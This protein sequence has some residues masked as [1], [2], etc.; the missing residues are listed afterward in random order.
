MSSPANPALLF[1]KLNKFQQVQI[2]QAHS[3]SVS[4]QPSQHSFDN[5]M[6]P[7]PIVQQQLAPP[8]PSHPASLQHGHSLSLAAV[9][10]VPLHSFMAFNAWD[11]FHWVSATIAPDG[12]CSP[13]MRLDP[14][15][16]MDQLLAPPTIPTYADSQPDFM[17]GFGLDVPEKTKED[18]PLPPLPTGVD[19]NLMHPQ[20]GCE[21]HQRCDLV[22]FAGCLEASEDGINVMT[23]FKIPESLLHARVHR[24]H[25]SSQE[26]VWKPSHVCSHYQD[27]VASRLLRL[28][29]MWRALLVKAH[30]SAR[31]TDMRMKIQMM[32]WGKWGYEA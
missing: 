31:A 13:D 2:S 4:P 3:A 27:W 12:L 7:P 11:I 19:T 16:P 10:F 9:P 18:L 25:L 5:V 22:G 17:H 6:P 23:S 1:F 20:Q 8:P 32:R 15:T 29:I 21:K 30:P 14:G 26:R 24:R 28:H